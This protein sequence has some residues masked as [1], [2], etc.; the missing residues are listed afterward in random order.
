MSKD[1]TTDQVAQ[2]GASCAVTGTVAKIGGVAAVKISS[3]HKSY[4]I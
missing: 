3:L 2:F 1:I 4:W